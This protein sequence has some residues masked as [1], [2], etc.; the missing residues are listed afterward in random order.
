[1]N[2]TRRAQLAVTAAISLSAITPATAE[3]IKIETPL[4]N[5]FL[6]LDP[7]AAPN[8]VQNFLNYVNDGDYA[9]S[10]IHR[11]ATIANSNAN[12]ILGGGY[13]LTDTGD[14]S[15]LLPDDQAT[16]IS[17]G[18]SNYGLVGEVL[19]DA[20]I[21][22]EFSR[23]NLRGTI[24]MARTSGLPD[25]ATNQWFINVTDNLGLDTLDGGF[26][27]FGQVTSG[28]DVVDAI[29]GLDDFTIGSPSNP[30][31]AFPLADVPLLTSALPPTIERD[32]VV[33]TRISVVPEPT[34][35]ALLTLGG[36]ALL[37]RRRA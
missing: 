23:S 37:R 14:I 34:S 16:L 19:T 25:S 22:N 11:N 12:A 4:G 29:H 26:T 30:S 1:M 2:I 18:R 8:T 9:N 6:E 13:T 3:E 32:E 36:L 17:Q 24:A 10:F 15:S 33:T 5:I 20:P 7:S 27:V 21:A 35:A 31:S 28:M